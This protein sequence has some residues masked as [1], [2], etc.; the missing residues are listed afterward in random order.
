MQ[1][2]KSLNKHYRDSSPSFKI[3]QNWFAEFR[4]SPI[5]TNGAVRSGRPIEVTTPEMVDK[6]HGIILDDRRVKVREIADD[7]FHDDLRKQKLKN[8]LYEKVN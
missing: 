8:V 2:Q 5:S 4:C 1:T 3:I 7:R 6:I